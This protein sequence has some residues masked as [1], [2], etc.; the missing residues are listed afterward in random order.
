MYVC[1]CV[2]KTKLRYHTGM[3][4]LVCMCIILDN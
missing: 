1:M 3:P 2:C 4:T